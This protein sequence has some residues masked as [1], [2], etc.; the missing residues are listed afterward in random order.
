MGKAWGWLCF[1]SNFANPEYFWTNKHTVLSTCSMAKELLHFVVLLLLHSQTAITATILWSKCRKEFLGRAIWVMWLWAATAGFEHHQK[2]NKIKKN[3]FFA[4]Y[5]A[6][7]A[8]F[9]TCP[10]NSR[11][12]RYLEIWQSGFSKFRSQSAERTESCVR[13]GANT[14]D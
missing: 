6:L 10:P 8:I 11:V 7:S 13:D 12:G 5:E 4:I 14:S 9:S 1:Q 2:K 3:L